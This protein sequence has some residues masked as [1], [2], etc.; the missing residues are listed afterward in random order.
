MMLTNSR[1]IRDVILFPLL[2]P[3]GEIGIAE[4]LRDLTDEPV[5]VVR[6]AA[7]S[8][9][10]KRKQTVISVITVISILGIAAGVMALIIALAINNG[11]QSKL[12]TTCSAR[13]RMSAFSKRTR[14]RH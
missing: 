13:R 1:S 3:E 9:A 5:R 7:L 8:C 10:P 6:C 2:R 11:F 4:R 14:L 12:Q